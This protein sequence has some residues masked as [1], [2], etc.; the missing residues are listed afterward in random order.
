M[1]KARQL[2]VSVENR[3]G[4][5]AQVAKVLG[6]AKVNILAFLTTTSDSAGTAHVVVD[7]VD[8][9]KKALDGAGLSY[10]EGD[11]LFVELKNAPGALGQFAE[12]LSAKGINI[13]SGYQTSVKGSK[14]ASVVLAVSDLEEAARVR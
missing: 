12:K 3:P 4:T 14:K 11:V 7:N 2:S 1:P 10:T 9:A 5:L 6:D 13:T 8:K